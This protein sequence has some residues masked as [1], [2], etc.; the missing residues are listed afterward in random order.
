MSATWQALVVESLEAVVEA[1]VEEGLAVGVVEGDVVR[2]GDDHIPSR[3][4]RVDEGPGEAERDGR[5]GA[6]GENGERG[7]RKWRKW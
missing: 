4:Q 6:N 2:G 3:S 7:R 5:N 1:Q